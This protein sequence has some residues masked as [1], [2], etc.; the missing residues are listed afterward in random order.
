MKRSQIQ[1]GVAAIAATAVSLVAVPIAQ[2]GDAVGG[3]PP[4]PAG[5]NL[6]ALTKLDTG[7][8]I[9][10][11]CLERSYNTKQIGAHDFPRGIYT[12]QVA[13]VRPTS[14]GQAILRRFYKFFQ[15]RKPD[16][17]PSVVEYR[18]N[19]GIDLV[20]AQG[21]ARYGHLRTM[22][23]FVVARSGA[24]LTLLYFLTNAQPQP[25]RNS[26]TLPQLVAKAVGSFSEDWATVP[27]NREASA[28]PPALHS[29]RGLVSP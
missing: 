25:L 7:C 21:H 27:T 9:A 10:P 16:W 5:L 28:T 15:G 19:G 29:L 12:S 3:L 4:G 11:K 23:R 20:V 13:K 22:E 24:R 1:A 18:S 26:A 8:A 14:S 6:P 2:A 17:N